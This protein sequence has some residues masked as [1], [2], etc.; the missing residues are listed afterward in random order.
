MKLNYAENS[1]NEIKI[2]Y[3]YHK[4]SFEYKPWKCKQIYG[5]RMSGRKGQDWGGTEE[6][7]YTEA[8]ENLVVADRL[9]FCLQWWGKG[10]MS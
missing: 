2:L 1:P 9:L 4:I 3:L 5:D 7:D 10:C 6:H 8:G